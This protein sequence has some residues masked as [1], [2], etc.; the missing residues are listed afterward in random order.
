MQRNIRVLSRNGET[1][2]VLEGDWTRDGVKQVINRYS[3]DSLYLN[4]EQIRLET[5]EKESEVKETTPEELAL[6]RFE[7]KKDENKTKS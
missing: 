1:A 2:V 6:K 7:E 4:G 3:P 5:E